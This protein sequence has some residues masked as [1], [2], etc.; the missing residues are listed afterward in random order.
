MLFRSL[1]GVPAL[2]RPELEA[3]RGVFR[4]SSVC[5]DTMALR[6]AEGSRGTD[7]FTRAFYLAQSG[8]GTVNFHPSG[9]LQSQL[10]LDRVTGNM[11][12]AGEHFED[13]HNAT[14]ALVQA[15]WAG[16]KKK[17][18]SAEAARAEEDDA[19]A[20]LALAAVA[21]F[22]DAGGGGEGKESKGGD[23]GGA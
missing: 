12:V 10:V 4:G 20:A 19:E 8:G 13:M 21:E 1:G 14:V 2:T 23:G 9:E 6:V 17:D 15:G 22:M 7:E 18:C 11:E 16:K 3:W 5:F